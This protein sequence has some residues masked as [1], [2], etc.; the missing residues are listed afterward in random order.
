MILRRDVLISVVEGASVQLVATPGAEWI[1][2][3]MPVLARNTI[4]ETIL[5]VSGVVGRYWS[6]RG[7]YVRLEGDLVAGEDNHVVLPSGSMVF[8]DPSSS[9]SP[10]EKVGPGTVRTWQKRSHVDAT[11]GSVLLGAALGAVAWMG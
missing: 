5:P 4:D 10:I 7:L 2:T 8:V 1:T 9:V 6:P 11:I 3:S